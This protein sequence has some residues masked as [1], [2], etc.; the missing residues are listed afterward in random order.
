MSARLNI[1]H[2]DASWGCLL[3]IEATL[4]GIN[5]MGSNI[6]LDATNGVSGLTQIDLRR[7][8][9]KTALGGVGL[10]AI[11][12]TVRGLA[13]LPVGTSLNGMPLSARGS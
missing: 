1:L 12:M 13:Q 9:V 4:D 8:G 2:N 5:P 7:R 11:F 3:G 10:P 6:A